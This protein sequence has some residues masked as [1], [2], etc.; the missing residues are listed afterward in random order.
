MIFYTIIYYHYAE[1]TDDLQLDDLQ[2]AGY[3][4][5]PFARLVL[6]VFISPELQRCSGVAVAVSFA[7][8]P[9]LN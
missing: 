8:R 4:G 7:L 5:L 6:R 3:E 2:V 9:P 1:Y